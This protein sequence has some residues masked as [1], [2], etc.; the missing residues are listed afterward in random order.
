[1]ELTKVLCTYDI[2]V[3]IDLHVEFLIVGV[4]AVYDSLVCL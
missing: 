1:M 3:Q 4:G 2:I